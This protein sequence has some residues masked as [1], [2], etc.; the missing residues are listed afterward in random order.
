MWKVQY[1]LFNYV[2]TVQIVLDM[3]LLECEN[4]VAFQTS[5]KF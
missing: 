2:R 4:S 3:V 5:S 1:C